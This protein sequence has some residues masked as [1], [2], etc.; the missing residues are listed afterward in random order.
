MRKYFLDY[1][2]K[3]AEDIEL[4]KKSGDRL[5]LKKLRVSYTGASPRVNLVV[6]GGDA[7]TSSA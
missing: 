2:E 3:A 7:E 6:S 5:A 4:L 1:T